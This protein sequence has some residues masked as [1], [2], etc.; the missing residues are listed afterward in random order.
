MKRQLSI[1][2]REGTPPCIKLSVVSAGGI[3][4]ACSVCERA[5]GI[6]PTRKPQAL[7]ARPAGGR[8]LRP[9]SDVTPNLRSISDIS[10]GS[11]KFL[12]GSAARHGR[13]DLLQA[14]G[15]MRG[16]WGPCKG[17]KGAAAG[18]R[19]SPRLQRCARRRLTIFGFGA[20]P[21]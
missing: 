21:G 8:R 12:S 6:I 18:K 1:R 13:I 16:A 10:G 15:G 19:S 5:G 2:R 7:P 3:H 9:I 20:G 4:H 14:W 11:N 17:S